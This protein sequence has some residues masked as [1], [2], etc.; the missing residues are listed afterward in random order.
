[1]KKFL[2]IAAAFIAVVVIAFTV[3]IK[4]YVTPE[5]VRAFLIP[6]AEN[7]LNRK[8]D[9]G[10][11]SIGLFKGIAVKD[12]AI[13]E[14][15]GKADFLRCRDFVLTFQLLPLLAKKVIIDELSLV[16]PKLTVIRD[17]EG[18][19]N[20][21]DI[22]K[23]EKSE[24][25][26]EETP[27]AGGKGL[28]IS[29]LVNKVSVKEAQFSLNDL[30]QELPDVS[31]T[32]DID[33]NI[34][35]VSSSELS[36]EGTI[37]IRLDEM[38][39]KKAPRPVRNVPA[40]LAYSVT[41]NLKSSDIHIDRGE[42]NLN[43]IPA[44]VSG[45][46][47]KLKETPEVNLLLSLPKVKAQDLQKTASLFTDLQGLDLSGNVSADVKIQGMPQKPDSL[48]ANGSILLEHVSVI[49]QDVKALL[50]GAI[51]FDEKLM[52]IDI[53]STIDKNTATIKG[54]VKNYFKNQDITLNVYAQKLDLDGLIPAGKKETKAP[55]SGAAPASG[56][57]GKDAE[58][59]DLKLTA[60][61]EV[62][63]DSAVYR[64]MAMDN[65]LM[66]YEL[67]NNKLNISR[68]SGDAEKGQFNLTSLVDLGVPGYRYTLSGT[69]KS[70]HSD[71][72]VNAF[73]PKAK[74]TVFGVVSSNLKANGAGT[75]PDA[76]KKNLTADADFSIIDGKITNSGITDKLSLFLNV[77]ELKTINLNQANGTVVIR[78][79]IARLD[80]LFS[81]DDLSMDP[82]GTIGLDESLDLA[83]DLRLSPRLTDKAMSSKITQYIKSSEGWGTVPL[84]VAG[85]LSDPKYRVDVAKVGKQVIEKKVDKLIDKLL[86]KKT[87]EQQ[88]ATQ[89]PQEQKPDAVKELFKGLFK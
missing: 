50:D 88:P 76:I 6:T 28:P 79:G 43:G 58:P 62:K 1:M 87:D 68:M 59:L 34:R 32:I 86:N 23:K 49:Y 73:F 3:F 8:I 78:N 11:V 12:F 55:E 31:T 18:R 19:Y 84:I 20:F 80:S 48:L 72:I 38:K 17:K 36:S 27:E 65:F 2:I 26:A 10:D 61:G 89:P 21:A 9:V 52:N 45:D 40:R 60:H 70:L 85:T 81:S 54:S 47:R 83:F 35:S 75:I 7:A 63:V 56:K 30:L 5:R 13:K 57:K 22:G 4:I 74:D 53:R 51:K 29:L 82:K 16:A 14:A 41:V 67:K 37:G 46:I 15:D 39:M 71:E 64:G 77:S 44:A 25:A 24:K 66:V 33:M 69:V 42:I